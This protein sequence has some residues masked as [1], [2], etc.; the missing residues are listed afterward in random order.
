MELPDT[1]V[2]IRRNGHIYTVQQTWRDFMGIPMGSL[3]YSVD[4]EIA[5]SATIDKP[6]EI[7]ELSSQLELFI[8]RY[9]KLIK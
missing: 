1:S 4:N 8:E 6:F 2:E 5:L 3:F 9:S 7:D